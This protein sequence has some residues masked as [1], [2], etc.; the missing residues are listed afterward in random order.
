MSG[1]WACRFTGRQVRIPARA[2]GARIWMARADFSFWIWNSV[3]DYDGYKYDPVWVEISCDGE[4]FVPFCSRMAGVNDD[5]EITAIGGWS[6]VF[7]DLAPYLGDTVQFRFRFRSD[8]RDVYAGSYIDDV[9]VSGR[10]SY[11]G[12]AEAPNVKV[13][14]SCAPSIVR[15]VLCLPEA[16]S[17]VLWLPEATSHKLQAANLLDVSGSSVLDLRPGANDVRALAPGVYFVRGPKTRDGKP[18]IETRK[19][20]LER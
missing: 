6:H 1:N 7:L 4:A 3:Q 20:I 8:N 2:A 11:A 17:G 15:G 19:V 14:A 10:R 18:A 13:R 5:P 9:K 12:V 16:A